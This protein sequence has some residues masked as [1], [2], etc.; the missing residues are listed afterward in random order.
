M[1]E[2]GPDLAG[3][4]RMKRQLLAPQMILSGAGQWSVAD[5]LHRADVA[6]A[7]GVTHAYYD[8][9]EN[10]VG[11]LPSDEVL[12]ALIDVLE[13]TEDEAAEVSRMIGAMR[14]T[15]GVE[16]D[17]QLMALLDS[18]PLTAA[19][20]CDSRLTVLASNP[21]ARVVSPMFDGGT[22]VLRAMYL[23][24]DAY[25]MIRN[26]AE[27][28]G[29]TAAW[30]KRLATDH[31]SDASFSRMV[32]EI[33]LKRPQFRELWESDVDPSADGEFLL[34]HPAVGKL[35][36]HYRRFGI[37]GRDDQFLVTLHADAGTPTHCG[38]R[39]LRDFASRDDPPPW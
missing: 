35:D 26:A 25:S 7:V 4:L 37:E 30:A 32:G 39:V 12:R 34:D 27:V 9:I 15:A 21:I 14:R 11:D 36:L 8:S 33:S 18:W 2:L 5:F 1:A 13:L 22:N 10:G 6:S 28:E 16:V 3:F 31:A 29:V 38:L 23:D 19:F 17:P 20:V 24:P